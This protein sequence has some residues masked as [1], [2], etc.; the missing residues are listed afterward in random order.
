M[1]LTRGLEGCHYKVEMIM[2][3][4]RLDA[5]NRRR[6]LKQVMAQQTAAA[7]LD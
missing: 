4:V 7:G 6:Y 3:W 1:V 5:A 2:A